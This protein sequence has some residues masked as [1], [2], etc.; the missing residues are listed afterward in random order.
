MGG[1]HRSHM[2]IP[3]I[4]YTLSPG[5]GILITANP[6]LQVA[7][8]LVSWISRVPIA[9]LLVPRPPISEFCG[10]GPL[11]HFDNIIPND[12]QELPAVK[13][14]SRGNVE[15]LAV[16]VRCDEEVMGGSRRIPKKKKEYM[17]VDC[18]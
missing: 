18:V 11:H 12:W 15:V 7:N 14:A 2:S 13:R 3:A 5:S 4:P 10:Q 8:D 6:V 16:R 9:T 17:S 1:R